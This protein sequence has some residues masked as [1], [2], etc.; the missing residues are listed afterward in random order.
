MECII[1]I[2]ITVLTPVSVG[3]GCCDHQTLVGR[4]GRHGCSELGRPLRSDG[5]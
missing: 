2:L 4:R 3:I 1:S 5:G